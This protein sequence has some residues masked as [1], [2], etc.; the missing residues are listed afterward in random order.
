VH[1]IEGVLLAPLALFTVLGWT[2]G[3]FGEWG[4]ATGLAYAV[5]LALVWAVPVLAPVGQGWGSVGVVAVAFAVLALGGHSGYAL[6][7]G[8]SI[9][10]LVLTRVPAP[11]TASPLSA[12]AFVVMLVLAAALWASALRAPP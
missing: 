3:A 7:L 9:L 8:A 6:L 10:A 4:R 12:T 11:G 5:V 1:A 2:G